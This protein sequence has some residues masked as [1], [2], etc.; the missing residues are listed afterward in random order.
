MRRPQE[1]FKG[2]RE[3]SI[4]TKTKKLKGELLLIHGTAD[5]EAH[6]QN[7]FAFAEELQN[8]GILFEMMIYPNKNLSNLEK[9]SSIHLFTKIADF[10]EKKLK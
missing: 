10:L 3:S 1:N 2:Y 4:L 6:I 9:N 5:N 7:T 8:N